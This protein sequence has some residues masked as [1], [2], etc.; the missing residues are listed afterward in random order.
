MLIACKHPVSAGNLTAFGPLSGRR[1]GGLARPRSGQEGA[2]LAVPGMWARHGWGRGRTLT[3]SRMSLSGLLE[4][5]TPEVLTDAV[6]RSTTEVIIKLAGPIRGLNV[7]ALVGI[8]DERAIGEVKGGNIKRVPIRRVFQVL[9]WATPS[10]ES[11]MQELTPPSKP[12]LEPP[13]RA[14]VVLAMALSPP[15]CGWRT[16]FVLS[17]L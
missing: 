1:R 13:T 17:F 12:N 11:K 3:E 2:R 8:S 9:C 16:R 5:L 15:G 14:P 4:I 7:R 10:P 6:R